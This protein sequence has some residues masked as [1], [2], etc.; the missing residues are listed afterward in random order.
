MQMKA[1]TEKE[2]QEKRAQEKNARK[3]KKIGKPL[4]QASEKPKVK[5]IEVKKKKLTEEQEAEL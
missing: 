5:K 1:D 3:I 4:M 2:I